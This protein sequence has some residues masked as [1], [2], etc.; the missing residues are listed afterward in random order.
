MCL[1][2]GI[3]RLADWAQTKLKRPM[4]QFIIVTE[5]LTASPLRI[6]HSK[7]QNPAAETERNNPI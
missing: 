6:N 2:A 1:N 3:E 5:T 4:I 7:S